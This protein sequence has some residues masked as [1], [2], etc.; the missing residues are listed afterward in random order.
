ME[1]EFKGQD[2]PLICLLLLA[3]QARGAGNPWL[4]LTGKGPGSDSGLSMK[5]REEAG[6]GCGSWREESGK[7]LGVG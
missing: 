7:A 3:L 4:S 2:L 1:K 5:A 6:N